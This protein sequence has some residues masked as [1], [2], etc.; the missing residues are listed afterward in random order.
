MDILGFVLYI[1]YL[2][3]GSL[4]E[5]QSKFFNTSLGLMV[6]AIFA[7]YLGFEIGVIFI[8]IAMILTVFSTVLDIKYRLFDKR[9]EIL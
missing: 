8:I 4:Y 5:R 7:L 6:L 1:L 9:K 3:Y 2:I